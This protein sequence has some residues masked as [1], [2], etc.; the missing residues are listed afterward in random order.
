MRS[1]QEALRA[2]EGVGAEVAMVR[3][4]DLELSAGPGAHLDDGPW[5]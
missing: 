4:D 2:A 5:F 1:R 3:V